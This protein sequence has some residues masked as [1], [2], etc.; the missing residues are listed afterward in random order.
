VRALPNARLALV[1]GAGHSVYFENAPVFNQLV[2]DFLRE[3][4]TIRQ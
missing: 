4:G 1:S 2:H 3:V